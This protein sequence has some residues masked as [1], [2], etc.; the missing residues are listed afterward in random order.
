MTG[1][2]KPGVFLKTLCRSHN[3]PGCGP[4]FQGNEQHTRVDA[5]PRLSPGATFAWGPATSSIAGQRRR[6]VVILL[7]CAGHPPCLGRRCPPRATAWLAT[8]APSPP[9]WHAGSHCL[10]F[11]PYESH[12]PPSP[13]NPAGCP[14]IGTTFLTSLPST[15]FP[16]HISWAPG[17]PCLGAWPG[18]S[19]GPGPWRCGPSRVPCRQSC[20][21]SPF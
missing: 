15:L 20:P 18:G 21:V 19:L 13:S 17:W 4:D 11:W 1:P 3:F 2:A 5:L 6:P 8:R 12:N 7:P 9:P 14:V 10:A 16:R